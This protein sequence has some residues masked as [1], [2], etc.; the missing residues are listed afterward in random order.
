MTVTAVNTSLVNRQ[1][2][3]EYLTML[4]MHVDWNGELLNLRALGEKGTD[5]FG[6][7]RENIWV[8]PKLDDAL[9]NITRNCM[10]W[11]QHGRGAFMV[12]G[13]CRPDC[14]LSGGAKETDVI[15]FTSMLVDLDTGNTKDKIEFVEKHL[16]P[17][18]MIVNSGG[19]TEEN[20][21]KLHAYWTFQEP[22][23]DVERIAQYRGLLAAKIGG[24]VNA[25][26]KI[27][28]IIRI[29]GS[30]YCK[31]NQFRTVTIER[32]KR[33]ESDVEEQIE[34]IEAMPVMPGIS[35]A[36]P[37]PTIEMMS[38]RA[39]SE[40]P[41]IPHIMNTPI[42][43]GGGDNN[44]WSVFSQVAGH[45]IRQ[46][47]MGNITIEEAQNLTYGWMH[48]QMRPPWPDERFRQEFVALMNRDAQSNGPILQ[49]ERPVEN[50]PIMTTDNRAASGLE[51]FFTWAA[52]RWSG[53]ARPERKFMVEGFLMAGQSH[54]VAAEGGIGKTFTMLDLAVK[55][56]SHNQGEQTDWLGM[57]LTD[58][59]AGKTVVMLTA[60]DDLTELQIRLHDIDPARRRLLAR[61]RLVLVPLQNAGGAFALIQKGPKGEALPAPR[62]SQLLNLM[63]Q[64]NATENPV[65]LVIIDTLNSMLHGEDIQASVIQEFYRE[66]H[67]ICGELGAA[68]VC[69]HHFRKR[70]RDPIETLEDAAQAVRGSSAVTASNRAVLAIWKSPSYDKRLRAMGMNPSEHDL[71][72]CGIVKGNNP[73]LHKG[74]KS[75]LRL[76]TGMLAD[77]SEQDMLKDGGFRNEE[78]AWMLFAIAQA[79][80]DRHPFQKN[81]D[82]GLSEGRRKQLPKALSH[83]TR[84]ELRE[85]IDWMIKERLIVMGALLGAPKKVSYIDVPGG[86]LDRGQGT[87]YEGTWK[88]PKWENF[89]YN[90]HTMRVE[91]KRPGGF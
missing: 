36:A 33:R 56:A 61:N 24:D 71:Y 85:M 20:T 34:R 70:G 55:V 13:V 32:H 88:I 74:K 51:G 8:D 15:Q 90:A 76:P 16:G 28:Q 58:L 80:N 49:Q 89:F 53:G 29:P 6:N 41:A 59:C 31:G 12:P 77:V 47:R 38:F 79:S 48:A 19:V 44:R 14:D 25:F 57:R 30:V 91:P 42:A 72:D 84:D 35:V 83:L 64:I 63:N 78:I 4:F 46:A 86:P 81:G 23:S 11:A 26:K 67:R 69:T 39:G 54:L 62:W 21:P 27:P 87:Q 50:K 45:N 68:L 37:A 5:G 40:R 82:N 10:R 17:A 60:E 43:E 52:H 66:A 75:L 3:D 22:S 73:Q 7:F 2:I 1:L 9:A 18:C 65:G